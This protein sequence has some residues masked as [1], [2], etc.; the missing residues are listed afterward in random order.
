MIQTF[1]DKVTAAAFHGKFGKR[2]PADIRKRTLDKLARIDAATKLTALEVPPSNRLE[3]LKGD[4]KGF[5]SI[6]IQGQWR[7]IF[8][9]QGGR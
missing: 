5:Y 7:I 3:A 2:T 8:K 4:L 6:R 9:W 1:A